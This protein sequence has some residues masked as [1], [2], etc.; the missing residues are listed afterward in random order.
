MVKMKAL[1]SHPSGELKLEEVPAPELG[2]NRY[3]PHDV[4][5]EVEYCGICGS[6]IHKWDADKTGVKT[7]PRS[8]VAGLESSVW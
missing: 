2:K 5:C 6:D 1:V 8:V 3:A 4:L 7:T